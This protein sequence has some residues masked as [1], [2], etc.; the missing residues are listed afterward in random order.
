MLWVSAVLTVERCL[1]LSDRLSYVASGSVM[2]WLADWST[3]LN[4]ALIRLPAFTLSA[5][6]SRC[7]TQRRDWYSITDALVSLHFGCECSKG[8]FSRSSYS[9]IYTDLSSSSWRCHAV[10]TSVHT[11]RRHPVS[12]KTAVFFIRRSTRSCC[13]TA[14]YTIGHRAFFVAIAL[15]ERPTGRCH[16]STVSKLH[17]FRVSY[18]AISCLSYP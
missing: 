16:L 4:G 11:D 2:P 7:R 13:Q 1:C 15:V 6:S 3:I 9:Y 18:P 8:S 17:L 12:T 14:L 10:P 5:D